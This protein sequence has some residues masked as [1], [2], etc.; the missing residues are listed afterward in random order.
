[1]QILTDD[2]WQRMTFGEVQSHG[3]LAVLP[4]MADLP[5]GPDYL[6]L[7]EAL[8]AGTLSITE[9]SEGGSVPELAV[10]N[11]GALPVLLLDGEELA[12][13]KQ[14]R[15][16][17]T[18]ILLKEHSKTVIPVSCV[19]QGRWHYAS[20][21]FQD[22]GNVMAAGQRANKGRAVSA[23]LASS[24]RRASDQG[25]VWAGVEE[26][27][28]S[29][30]VASETGAM[31]DVYAHV[32]RDLASLLRAFTPVP[33]QRGMATFIGGRI[34]GVE[35][36][37]HPRAFAKVFEKLLRS[38]ALDAF[39]HPASD[40]A[41]ADPELARQ[42]LAAIT[43]SSVQ[44]YAALGY[45]QEHRINGKSALGSALTVE[46][47]LIHL[48]LL[49]TTTTPGDDDEAVPFPRSYWVQ[50][51]RLLAGCYPGAPGHRE[52]LRKLDGL[53]DAGIRAVI[54][55]MEPE[56]TDHQGRAF[57]PYEDA[58]SSLAVAQG[59]A[60]NCLR[61]PIPDQCVPTRETMRQILDAIDAFLERGLPTFIHCWGGKG[62]TGTVVG[63]W[64]AR[65]GVAT[66]DEALR[67]VQHLRRNDPTANQP[68]PENR[69]Q[70]AMVRNWQL[71]E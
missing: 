50:P 52:L 69:L 61:L 39:R 38:Y 70:C 45:G 46:D 32:E 33:G 12:G 60:M 9:I 13:A 55:L 40:T 21:E 4:I 51:G 34:A 68:S 54:N 25:E 71:G 53:L 10:A 29:F 23:N 47:A 59:V 14:N 15:V 49:A 2:I 65:H 1:M 11:T 24:G 48:S 6:T 44:S 57:S 56:E 20:R 43:G 31:R 30:D 3:A 26:M 41:G 27:A 37:S 36:L 5:D 66:G 42:F 8:A 63:C 17:N 58:L 35:Y 7:G 19:E 64:L 62:R 18:T 16:V 22:S 28:C 67:M